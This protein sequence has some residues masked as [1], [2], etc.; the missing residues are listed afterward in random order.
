MGGKGVG[1]RLDMTVALPL[2]APT[3]QKQ[4]ESCVLCSRLGALHASQ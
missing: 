2:Y 1:I 4:A 3:R